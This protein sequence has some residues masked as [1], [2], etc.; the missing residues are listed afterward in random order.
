MHEILGRRGPEVL[1]RGRL[2]QKQYLGKGV[3]KESATAVRA[4]GKKKQ[5][6]HHFLK[7]QR[8]QVYTGRG[9]WG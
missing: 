5:D 8:T 1:A 7:T 2:P 6:D 4:E 9:R 3:R